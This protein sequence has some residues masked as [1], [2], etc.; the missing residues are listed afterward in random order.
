MSSQEFYSESGRS[1]NYPLAWGLL[2]FLQKGAPIMR[3]KNN[4]HE[5]PMKYYEAVIKTRDANKATDI[6][7]KDVDMQK[8]ADDFTKF[9]NSNSLIKKAIRFDP[10]KKRK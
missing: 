1:D 3:S 8:F 2:F 5:I 9:W 6:A 10:L 7:W 4:Y